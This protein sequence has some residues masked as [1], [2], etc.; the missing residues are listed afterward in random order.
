MEPPS[1]L[2]NPK[3]VFRL[4]REGHTHKQVFVFL[5]HERVSSELYYCLVVYVME[6][7]QSD[8]MKHLYLNNKGLM[9]FEKKS[10][11]N[12]YSVH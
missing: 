1:R 4:L 12:N 11:Y 3:A 8:G 2:L 6:I 5:S 7:S 10:Y 9:D